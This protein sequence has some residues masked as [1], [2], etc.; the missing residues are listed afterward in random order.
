MKKTYMSVFAIFMVLTLVIGFFINTFGHERIFKDEEVSIG[1]VMASL[2]GEREL[3][4]KDQFEVMCVNRDIQL[5]IQNS[6]NSDKVQGERIKE[7][8]KSGIN[9]LVVDSVSTRSKE[10][11]DSIEY[12]LDNE[13]NVVFLENKVESYA[14]KCSFVGFESTLV[15][16]DSVSKYSKITEKT[17]D[18]CMNLYNGGSNEKICITSL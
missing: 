11:E 13:V 14:D 7:L 2:D 8:V 6:E 4:L 17:L 15:V 9:V 10:L 3:L 16:G 18:V 5:R 1:V 12:A